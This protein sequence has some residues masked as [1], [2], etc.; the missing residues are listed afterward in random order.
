MKMRRNKRSV[1]AKSP[2]F[3]KAS[4]KEFDF[5]SVGNREPLKVLCRG[6]KSPCLHGSCDQD[7]PTVLERRGLEDRVEAAAVVQAIDEQS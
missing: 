7:G 4:Q 6:S 1:V 2:G 3:Y 5:H